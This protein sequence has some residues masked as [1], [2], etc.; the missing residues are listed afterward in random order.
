[1]LLHHRQQRVRKPWELL[2]QLLRQAQQSSLALGA[3]LAHLEEVVHLAEGRT[4][5]DL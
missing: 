5:E 2:G 1:M 4:N 3:R